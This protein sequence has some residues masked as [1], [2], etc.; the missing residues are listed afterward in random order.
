[1]NDRAHK[2]NSHNAKDDDDQRQHVKPLDFDGIRKL[3]KTLDDFVSRDSIPE[4]ADVELIHKILEDWSVEQKKIIAEY[5]VQLVEH[6]PSHV[7]KLLQC[8]MYLLQTDDVLDSD[9]VQRFY[10][11]AWNWV[12]L[13]AC[14]DHNSE[15]VQSAAVQEEAVGLGRLENWESALKK[16][17][18]TNRPSLLLTLPARDL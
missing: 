12:K 4:S 1:M 5:V 9:E 18:E 17:E 11:S 16:A 15:R 7:P 6:N 2:L 3:R 13:G 14:K 8:F 10:N